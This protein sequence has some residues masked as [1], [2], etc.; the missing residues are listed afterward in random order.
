MLESMVREL[1]KFMSQ[2]TINDIDRSTFLVCNLN[3]Y[4]NKITISLVFM[5]DWDSIESDGYN[6]V[7]VEGKGAVFTFPPYWLSIPKELTMAYF[8]A[9]IDEFYE[10]EDWL[11]NGSASGS[12]GSGAGI[13]NGCNNNCGCVNGTQNA[14]TNNSTSGPHPIIYQ[15]YV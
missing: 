12:T 6:C 11:D 15:N 7:T 14:T 4:K 5:R 1:D 9:I 13:N 8:E 3:D 10:N 2:K